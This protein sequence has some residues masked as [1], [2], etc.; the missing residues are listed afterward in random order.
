M[1]ISSGLLS[2]CGLSCRATVWFK[3]DL[4]IP[5]EWKGKEVHLIW[6]SQ[7]EAMIF[8]NGVPTQGKRCVE[9][10]F[11]F[12]LRIYLLIVSVRFKFENRAWNACASWFPISTNGIVLNAAPFALLCSAAQD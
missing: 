8:E 12:A 11:G 3:L 5:K 6:D 2:L 1:F 7:S 9:P 10:P 4:R